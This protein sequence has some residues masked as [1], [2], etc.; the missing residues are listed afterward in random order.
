LQTAVVFGPQMSAD[1]R[2]SLLERFG[3]LSDVAFSDFEPDLTRLYAEADIFAGGERL[4]S[5]LEHRPLVIDQAAAGNPAV[6]LG[7]LLASI[8][9]NRLTGRNRFFSTASIR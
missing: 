5:L 9:Y 7:S 6:D 8:S 4:L 1:A 3:Y 2:A